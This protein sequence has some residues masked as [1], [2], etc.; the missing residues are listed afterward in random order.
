MHR[1]D[2]RLHILRGKRA[3]AF[4]PG[5]PQLEAAVRSRAA[6]AVRAHL[7]QHQPVQLLTPRWSGGPRFLED[8]SQDL[9]VGVPSLSG[10][11][12]SLAGL[13][14]LPSTSQWAALT[15]LLVE[16]LP[17]N[18]SRIGPIR[19]PVG[20]IGFVNALRAIFEGVSER[21]CVILLHGAEHLEIETW[22]DLADAYSQH[23]RD[24]GQTAG[25]NLLLAGMVHGRELA[26]PGLR[27]LRLPDYG[28]RETMEVL[29]EFCGMAERSSL[30]LAARLTGGLPRL[31]HA[32]GEHGARRGRLEDTEEGLRAILAPVLEEVRGAVGI[33]NSD[34]RLGPRL[35]ELAPC[36][37]PLPWN[38]Q[39]DPQLEVAGLI[40]RAGKGAQLRSPLLLSEPV[41]ESEDRAAFSAE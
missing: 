38:P 32:V 24:M 31:V 39:T 8:L 5:Q 26:V 12:H 25:P 7:R 19:Q 23:R 27:K 41:G 29:V 36:L 37:Q 20:R 30:R 18:T 14:G 10:C 17:L 33:L 28:M 6:R 22:I 3:G 15:D 1:L 35:E 4:D 21:Q 9:T 16:A 11:V 40:R 2:R 34:E 13:A